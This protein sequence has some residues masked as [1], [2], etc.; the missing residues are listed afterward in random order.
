MSDQGIRGVLFDLDETIHSRE[1]AFWTWLESEAR[2][3]GVQLERDRIAEL[4]ARGRGDKATL[5][6]HLSRVF[7]WQGNHEQH[8]ERFRAGLAAHVEL[9]HGVREL[10]VRLRRQYRLGLVTNGTGATQRAKLSSLELEELFDP[11][12]ISGEVGFRKP[13]RRIF[14]L[15]IASWGL[16][17]ESVLFVGDDP[18]SDIQGAREAGMRALRIGHDGIPSVLRLEAWLQEQPT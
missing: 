11:L 5:L 7:E 4:D 2:R 6:E 9:E 14:E 18:I 8:M 17:P 15:A 3:L 16:P 13:D 10:L 12:V 1:S